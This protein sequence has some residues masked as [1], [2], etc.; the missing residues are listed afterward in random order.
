METIHVLLVSDGTDDIQR[1]RDLLAEDKNALLRYHLD[2]ADAFNE[3]Q[4]ALV[5]NTHDVYLLD[6]VIPGARVSVSDFLK[7]VNVGGCSSPTIFL[8]TAS[9]IDAERA[10]D[11]CGA[12]G[13][14]H[15][16]RDFSDRVV[17]HAINYAV[18]HFKQ[19]QE[20]GEQLAHVQQQ[21]SEVNR[22][23]GRRW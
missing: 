8:T 1:I 7:Q 13:Y 12:A 10:V 4:R 22:K 11:D 21:L 5:R 6:Q 20:I 19:L 9:D 23:L 15:K 18:R 3:A 2:V 14:L 17:K 16:Y